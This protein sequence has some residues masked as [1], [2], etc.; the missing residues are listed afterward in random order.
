[1]TCFS[2][3]EEKCI[4][5]ERV[6]ISLDN[7]V[8]AKS[9]A[10]TSPLA[11]GPSRRSAVTSFC[12]W[13]NWNHVIATL[14]NLPLKEKNTALPHSRNTAGTFVPCLA[15]WTDVA[16]SGEA[17]AARCSSVRDPCDTSTALGQ[18]QKLRVIPLLL[19]HC[20]WLV[21]LF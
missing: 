10:P 12:F 18:L 11:A 6:S 8:R 13:Y 21:K 14:K 9:S 16:V 17:W 2:L 3:L 15:L 7:A 20:F 1:M 5:E 19:T 4:K